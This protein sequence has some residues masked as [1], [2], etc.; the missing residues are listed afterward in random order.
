MDFKELLSKY[1]NHVLQ[2]EGTDFMDTVNGGCLSD[3]V[4]TPEEVEELE[5]IQDDIRS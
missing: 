3:V 1:M 4:F 5:R 2:Y